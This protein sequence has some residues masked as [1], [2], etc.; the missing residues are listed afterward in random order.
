MFSMAFSSRKGRILA[1]CLQGSVQR[2]FQC[3]GRQ[4]LF[5]SQRKNIALEI[6]IV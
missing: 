2:E 5:V 4:S 6:E 3:V 1:V